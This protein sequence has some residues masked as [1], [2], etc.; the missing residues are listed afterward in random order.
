MHQLNTHFIR[1]EKPSHFSDHWTLQ[2]STHFI[3]MEKTF[4]F[5]DHWTHQSNSHFTRVE[6]TSHFPDYWTRKIKLTLYRNEENIYFPDHWTLRLNSHFI[7]VVRT[8]HFRFVVIETRSPPSI[9]QRARA[10]VQLRDTSYTLIQLV[11]LESMSF[12]MAYPTD[13]ITIIKRGRYKKHMDNDTSWK[14]SM[15]ICLILGVESL[16]D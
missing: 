2:L 11:V 15:L 6:K 4:H 10:S 1:V 8:S 9:W 3:R 7:R 13:Q 5:P 14:M 12:S 16:Y